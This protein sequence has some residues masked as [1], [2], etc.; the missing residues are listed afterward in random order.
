LLLE[1]DCKVTENHTP[2]PIRDGPG[3]TSLAEWG[4]H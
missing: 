4:Y 3:I 1:Y 2:R